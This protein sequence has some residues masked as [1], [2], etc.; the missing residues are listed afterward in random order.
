MRYLF[1]RSAPAG[2]SAAATE[3][4]MNERYLRAAS[5]TSGALVIAAWLTGCREPTQITFEVSTDLPCA[6]VDDTS[7]A[8]GTLADVERKP[9]TATAAKATCVDGRIGALVVAPSGDSDVEI[10]V[11]IVTGVGGTSP[12]ACVTPDYRGCIVARRALK[13]IPHTSL[14]VNIPMRANCKDVPCDAAGFTTCAAGRCVSARIDSAACE[15][16]GCDEPPAPSGSCATAPDPAGVTTSGW[17]PIAPM[18][19]I[20]EKGRSLHTAVWTCSELLVFGG[21]DDSNSANSDLLAFAPATNTWRRVGT[22]PLVNRR[23]HTAVWTGT[24]MIVWGGLVVVPVDG[25]NAGDFVGDGAI[26]DPS[27]NEWTYIPEDPIGGG[28]IGHV[29]AWSTT[30]S[31]ML[32]WGGTQQGAAF[33]PVT[34]TWRSIAAS[35]AELGNRFLAG[36][37]FVND[38]LIV[39][40]GSTTDGKKYANGASYDPKTDTWT[41]L[42]AVA[43]AERDQPTAVIGQLGIREGVFFYA[44]GGR[45]T[46]SVFFDGVS[47]TVVPTAP[48]NDLP[49]P[50]R[51]NTYVWLA[52]GRAFVWGG[53]L[54]DSTTAL[55][56][57]AVFDPS[58]GTWS[59][60]PASPLT[61]RSGGT[62]TW[63]GRYAI[64]VGG[65]HGHHGHGHGDF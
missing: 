9:T 62:A 8:V 61:A 15:G 50:G 18:T 35:P 38:R 5:A 22:A 24:Q 2:G 42:P 60:L 39:F 51:V 54:D 14:K 31:E 56:T 19:S 4:D 47:G 13:Y 37:A 32:V 45:V 55:A 23:L 57:G 48:A 25:R 53:R 28:R 29:A 20:G 21:G 17:T 26:Y 6:N 3:A 40:G 58:R 41:M 52:G 34:R 43:V 16:A 63:T 65:G 59:A 10:G 64:L 7:I 46:D 36:G 49:S 33:N 11:R 27:T 30:T 44:G 12:E 1:A